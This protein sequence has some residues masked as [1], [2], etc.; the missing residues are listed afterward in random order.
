MRNSYSGRHCGVCKK[1]LAHSYFSLSKRSQTV[2]PTP[3]GDVVMVADDELLT[4]F[5]SE[6]C[7]RYAEAAISSTLTS[8]YPAASATVPCSLCLRPVNRSKPHVAVSMTDFEDASEPWLVSARVVDERELAVY[9]RRCAEPR[10]ATKVF[11]EA[12]LGIG[13]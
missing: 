13:A 9:C 2:K 8:P 10:P 5:C 4:D 7:A 12:E 1:E 6:E 11:D 3:S